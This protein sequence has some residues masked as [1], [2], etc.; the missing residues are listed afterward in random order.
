MSEK[1]GR[2]AALFAES[3]DEL[4]DLLLQHETLSTAQVELAWV[5][6][7]LDAPA[8]K[9][10]WIPDRRPLGT[11]FVATP[12]TLPIYST[13]LF[14]LS[15]ALVGNRVVLR[16][17]STTRSCVEHVVKLVEAAGLDIELADRS[18]S[19]FAD[20]AHREADGMIFCGSVEHARQLDLTL[21]DDI[22]LLCQGPGVCA[23][24]VTADANIEDA[25]RT[26]L[27]TRLF[28]NGQDCL[29]T[30]RVYVAD[31]I[32]EEFITR[33]LALAGRLRIG[34]NDRAE[35][36][37]GPLLVP[38]AAERWFT[39]VPAGATVLRAGGDRGGDMYDLRVVE[40]V[41]D[42]EVVLSEKY[43]PVLPIVRYR[44]DGELREMLQLGN[45]ALGL[46]VAG[47]T[48]V[49]GTLDFSHVAV[50][51]VLFDFEDA[52]APF[53]GARS[54]TLLRQGGRRSSGPVL[55]PFAMS[56]QAGAR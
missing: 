43:C 20:R 51:S 28:N 48:P 39:E 54:T 8:H 7:A 5:A 37:L 36:D 33:L 31:A 6:S 35:T 14:A 49:H 16:P 38:A 50:N 41:P 44:T 15:S 10:D 27:R 21:P 4:I 18:W 22:R 52:W 53:G 29:A 11:V 1:L 13:L 26:A 12:A 19:S 2:L 32:A 9:V 24:V 34:P 55:V 3:R 46:T 40:A 30:E 45:F 42:A 47:S 25:A 56:D 17:S 23:M